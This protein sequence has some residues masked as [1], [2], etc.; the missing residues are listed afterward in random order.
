MTTPHW[1]SCGSRS[2]NVGGNAKERASLQ[3]WK[4][5]N[6]WVQQEKEWEQNELTARPPKD[7]PLWIRKGDESKHTSFKDQ[8]AAAY[9]NIFFNNQYDY[10]RAGNGSGGNGEPD[11]NPNEGSK[12]S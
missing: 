8:V 9:R 10:P 7:D 11:D 4:D 6:A 3:A 2:S 12:E 1:C 5:W